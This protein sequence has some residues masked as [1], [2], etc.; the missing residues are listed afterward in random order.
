MRVLFVLLTLALLAPAA[1]AELTVEEALQD[2]TPNCESGG[3][4]TG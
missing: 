1:A 3:T 2:L 4:T